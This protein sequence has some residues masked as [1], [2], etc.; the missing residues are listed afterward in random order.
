MKTALLSEALKSTSS[1]HT[2]ALGLEFYQWFRTLVRR[3]LRDNLE[4]E[5]TPD[6]SVGFAFIIRFENDAPLGQSDLNF[7][8][9]KRT[10]QT[11][12]ELTE[13][14]K[15]NWVAATENVCKI[16]IELAQVFFAMG[17]LCTT[18]ASNPLIF[19]D[20]RRPSK[21]FFERRSNGG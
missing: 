21:T 9:S 4:N 16:R 19:F 15:L 11:Q 7:A 13:I 2:L 12:V 20:L 8:T 18:D 17:S 5:I 10:L 1:A 14:C 6:C 3:C